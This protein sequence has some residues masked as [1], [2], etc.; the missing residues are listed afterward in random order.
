MESDIL[1]CNY[2]GKLISPNAKFCPHC[3]EPIP[4]KRKLNTDAVII[5][6]V[7]I[8]IL[9]YLLSTLLNQNDEFVT[10]GYYKKATPYV[11]SYNRVFSIYVKNFSDT[12]EMWAKIQKFAKEQM[13]TSGGN[14]VVL[15]FDDL[16]HTP[17]VTYTGLEFDKKYE[18]YCIASF[19]RYPNGKMEFY[20]YPFIDK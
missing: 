12:P 19:Y 1:K 20:K 7:V 17:D 15:F 11:S 6:V 4:Q 5:I 2:C 3:G 8:G 16:L 14:T 18:R 10:I 13:Y 9:V